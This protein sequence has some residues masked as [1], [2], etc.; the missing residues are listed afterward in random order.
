MDEA[1]MRP[2]EPTWNTAHVAVLFA[3][4][5]SQPIFDL[6]ARTPEFFPAR[7]STPGEIVWL[8]AALGLIGPVIVASLDVAGHAIGPRAGRAIHVLL[9]ALLI[10]LIA[11]QIA[12]R[13]AVFSGVEFVLAGC[14]A[15]LFAIAYARLRLARSVLSVMTPSLALVPALFVGTPSIRSQLFAGDPTARAATAITN[16][17]P[18]V[19]VVFD[20]FNVAA[21]Q[22]EQ[23][24]IDST[25]FPNFARLSRQSTWFRNATAVSDDTTYAVPAILTGKYP[26]GRKT[27]TPSDYPDNLFTLLGARYRLEVFETWTTL[28]PSRLCQARAKQP[29]V[30]RLR[31]LAAD[32]GLIYL[33]IVLPPAAVQRLPPVTS[34]WKGF[35]GHGSTGAKTRADGDLRSAASDVRALQDPTSQFAALVSTISPSHDAVLYFIHCSL[36]HLPWQFLPSGM[37]YG[38]LDNWSLPHGALHDRWGSDGWE[39]TQGMQRYLLQVGYTDALLGR[40]L[41]RLEAIGLYDA[42]LVAV[43]ADHGTSFR[44][45]DERRVATATNIAE[46]AWVPMFIKR[47]Y[48]RSA[49]VS[50]SPVETIDLLPTVAEILDIRIPWKVDGRSRVAEG[51]SRA[52]RWIFNGGKGGYPIPSFDEF[53]RLRREQNSTF[54]TEGWSTVFSVGPQSG[55]IGM[56]GALDR[57]PR[58]DRCTVEIDSSELYTIGRRGS[59]FVPSHVRGEIRGEAG[60][61]TLD[62]AVAVNGIVRATTRPFVEGARLKFTAMVPEDSFHEG[63]NRID[64]LTARQTA[65][66]GALELLGTHRLTQ[67]NRS[68]R[69]A[70]G[71]SI[72]TASGAT[73]PVRADAVNGWIDDMEIGYGTIAVAGWALDTATEDPPIAIIVLLDGEVVYAGKTGIERPDLVTTGSPAGARW[74]GFQYRVSPLNTRSQ[75][76]P[77]RLRVFGV[78][79]RGVASELHR[80]HAYVM[81]ADADGLPQLVSLWNGRRLP[82]VA[83]GAAGALESAAFKNDKALFTGWAMTGADGEP[84]DEVAVFVDGRFLVAGRTDQRRSDLAGRATGTGGF[85]FEVF[86]DAPVTPPLVEAFAISRGSTTATALGRRIF[87]HA[88][89]R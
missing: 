28:C 81:S 45:N 87:N 82:V 51:T 48:Q 62:L 76:E 42:A 34:T 18:V 4:G 89:T 72:Q 2:N 6:L 74:C 24:Q 53:L 32:L 75:P 86:A 79:S 63:A 77:W 1:R 66:A 7:Q 20:E 23:G 31:V 60:C 19:M 21:L 33:H 73:I 17:A 50:D 25:R 88:T 26:A 65:D 3:V 29:L 12:K 35:W 59:G 44:V 13:V 37:R 58:N 83:S 41:D 15:I 10:G 43:I 57:G 64:V 61:R 52:R 38:P 14:A 84:V 69:T 78:S 49:A 70:E 22:D 54:G 8:V 68:V 5:V 47:P 46:L 16:P 9:I 55:R 80:Y 56:R 39:A 85:R 36:P 67:Y 40:L 30:D 27:P 71:E 11:L